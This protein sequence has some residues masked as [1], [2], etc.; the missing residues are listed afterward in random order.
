MD[1]RRPGRHRRDRWHRGIRRS[2]SNYVVNNG[3]GTT[4]T[5]ESAGAAGGGGGAGGSGG[6]AGTATS[7]ITGLTSYTEDMARQ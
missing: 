2:N 5:N 3:D 6:N 4:T 1:D 7:E